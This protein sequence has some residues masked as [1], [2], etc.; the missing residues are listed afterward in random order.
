MRRFP[1]ARGLPVDRK[2]QARCKKTL[3]AGYRRALRE[4]GARV[5]FAGGA[6]CDAADVGNA[7][8][9]VESYS[10]TGEIRRKSTYFDTM[11]SKSGR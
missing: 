6:K 3:L 9:Y 8:K 11:R 5:V 4:S 2:Q 1:G 7:S 10:G